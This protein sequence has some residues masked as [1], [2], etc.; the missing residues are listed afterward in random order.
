MK[1]LYISALL[2]ASVATVSAQKSG[3]FT[4]LISLPA[5]AINV[6]R[7]IDTLEPASFS[8]T[9]FTSDMN[10]FTLY[11]APTLGY[12]TGTNTYAD[13]KKGQQYNIATGT[14]VS[15]VIVQYYMTNASNPN[16]SVTSH[17]VTSGV[18]AISPSATT[19]SVALGS[20]PVISGGIGFNNFTF[21]SAV[22]MSGDVVFAVNIPSTAGD[23]L[24][25]VSTK[26]NC[27]A[28]GDLSWELWDNSGAPTWST[29][30]D[31][32]QISS[33]N[34]LNVDLAIY[35]IVNTPTG[36]YGLSKNGLAITA[37][38]PNPANG[39]INLGYSLENASK[40]TIEIMDAMGRVINTIDLGTVVAGENRYIFDASNL[41]VG[42]YYYSISTGSSKLVNRFT[43]VK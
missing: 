25:V 29:L 14:T 17:P 23:T 38:Y 9:C 41:A 2:V 22:A 11:G 21:A 3:N 31:N 6:D 30:A 19:G 28:A 8:Q 32:W 40:V 35:P 37:A 12:V 20:L 43:V 27:A 39:L 33:G 34:P 7:A 13:M 18:P 24:A 15:G 36:V 4:E 10:P 16:I 5:S 1:K 26:D 42:N